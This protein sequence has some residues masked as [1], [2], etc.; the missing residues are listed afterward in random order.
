MMTVVTSA[1]RALFYLRFVCVLVCLSAYAKAT[2]PIFTGGVVSGAK[3]GP[4]R[5]G[6]DP[7]NKAKNT[8]FSH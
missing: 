7:L 8:F 6:A 2:C 5:F 3:E 4:S 1:E